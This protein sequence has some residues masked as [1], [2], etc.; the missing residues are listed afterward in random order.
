MSWIK[1]DIVIVGGG[2]VGLAMAASLADTGLAITIIEKYC[3]DEM[4]KRNCLKPTQP[5]VQDFAIRVSAVSPANQQFLYNLGVLQRIPQER[6]ADYELM[7]VW[8]G[9]GSGCVDFDAA[10]IAQ[11]KLG[12]IIENET[13]RAALFEQV[14]QHSNIQI[15]ENKDIDFIE[16]QPV[17]SAQTVEI[18]LTDGTTL[19]AQLLI[20]ADGAFSA[21]R[22]KLAIETYEQS[23]RQ[24]AFVANVVC[25]HPH[26]NTAW[27][28][29]TSSGPV[30]FLPL[31]YE[32]LCSVVWSVDDN[33][34]N[35]LADLAPELFTEKLSEAF[36]GRLGKLKIVSDFRGFPLIKRH[37][38]E[39][40]VGR[41]ALIGDAA[42][43]IHPLAGQGVNL[44]FQDVI[45]LSQ[46][47]K[48][49]IMQERDFGCRSQLRSFER[50]R[51]AENTQMQE[52]MSGFKWLF[53][54]QSMPVT[55]LRNWAMSRINQSS[56]I[57]NSI[58]KKAIGW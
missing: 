54:Q 11:P 52:V 41:C 20:G 15:L 30:A 22:D 51:K 53:G 12:S 24:T 17:D 36:E 25:E 57:K 33:K 39:Y 5:G 35:Q 56:L 40:I 7:R 55:I 21:V 19:S 48:Q 32:N 44:G 58:I 26:Q 9:D 1:S 4:L 3:F 43:T 18:G 14:S 10:E 8:D 23:Y 37:A 50:T 6:I 16:Q 45:C 27:Q 34:A 28:R 29:F 42:H 46:S 47:I 31:P 2:M 49:L 13:I 38:S